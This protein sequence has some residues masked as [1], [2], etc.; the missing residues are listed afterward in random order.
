MWAGSDAARVADGEV[1]RQTY[2]T[3]AGY[4]RHLERSDLARDLV[5]AELD[6]RVVGYARVEWNDSNDGERWYE[7]VCNVEPAQRRRGIGAALL[8][9]TERRRLAIA[10]DQDAAETIDRPRW[11][12]T[13]NFDGDVGGRMLLEGAGYEAFR[14][15]ASMRRRDLDDIPDAELPDGLEIRPIRDDRTEMRR[16]FDADIE[17]FRDHFGWSEGSDEQFAA[18]VQDAWK[19]RPNLTINYGLRWEGALNPSG[20]DTRPCSYVQPCASPL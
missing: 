17:A 8:G 12:T 14:H 6:D 1:E 19:V 16:V 18:F 3:M 9:W 10:A 13:F 5:I 11:L 4:Y 2:D 7:G 15:F 20:V